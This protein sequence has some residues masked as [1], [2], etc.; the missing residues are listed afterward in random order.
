MESLSFQGEIDPPA[1]YFT[2]KRERCQ[3]FFV[4]NDSFFTL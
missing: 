2:L 4:K 3:Y 1:Y